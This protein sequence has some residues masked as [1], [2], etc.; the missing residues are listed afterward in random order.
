MPSTF[1]PGSG[2]GASSPIK[3]TTT[4]ASPGFSTRRNDTSPSSSASQVARA[5]FAAATKSSARAGRNSSWSR[6]AISG[7]RTCTASGKASAGQW[8]KTSHSS[9]LPA[10]FACQTMNGR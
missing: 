3:R 4:V 8:Q 6:L 7:S 5:R 9:S 1:T 10:G 2:T